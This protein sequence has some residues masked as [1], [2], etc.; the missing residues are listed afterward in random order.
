MTTFDMM[1]SSFTTRH[2]V[3]WGSC[4][5][6]RYPHQRCA[7]GGAWRS[8]HLCH[9][10]IALIHQILRPAVLVEDA[11]R[12]RVQADVVI[13]RCED[14]LELNRTPRGQAGDCGR[15]APMTWP[16]FMPPPA[17]RAHDSCGQWSRPSVLLMRGVR[18]NSP[19]T[20]TET[21]FSRPRACK[22]STSAE[23]AGVEQRHVA[24]AFDEVLAV[25]AVPVPAAEVQRHHAG[26]GFDQP[27]R[28]A[29]VAD[30]ARGA[31][32]LESGIVVAVA[33]QRRASLPSRDRG[34]PPAAKM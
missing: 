19:Q 25:R 26:A 1:A 29:E 31:V 13:Q 5:C 27:A 15:F 30:H 8:N 28:D 20:T 16:V 18:P 2:R 24:A 33:T 3:S 6:N 21:S 10:V 9:R 7:Y 4:N 32:A 23:T 34:L 17:R 22:S 12:K 11:C 14:F